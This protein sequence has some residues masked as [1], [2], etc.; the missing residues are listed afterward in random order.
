MWPEES[1]RKP[2]KGH[3]NKPEVFHLMPGQVCVIAISGMESP[4]VRGGM[5]YLRQIWGQYVAKYISSSLH[6]FSL[7]T[8][9]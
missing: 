3:R 4:R 5:V 8:Y 1:E 9:G 7:M 6:L 2:W